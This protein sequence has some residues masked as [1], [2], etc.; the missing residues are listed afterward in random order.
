MAA[1]KRKQ[2]LYFPPDMLRDIEAEAI[3]LDHSTSWV[4]QRAWGIARME[5]KK[6][7]GNDLAVEA[8]H[9]EAARRSAPHGRA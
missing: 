4:V 2:S 5:L 9:G 7:P 8:G 3:R 6:M 1:D